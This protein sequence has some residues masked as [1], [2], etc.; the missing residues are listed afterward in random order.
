MYLKHKLVIAIIWVA[1]FLIGFLPFYLFDLRVTDSFV[2]A[3]VTFLSIVFGFYM[4][5]G[6]ILYGSSYVKELKE[7]DQKKPYQRLI[8]TFVAYFRKAS[9]FTITT[10]VFLLLNLLLPDVCKNIRLVNAFVNS[11]LLAMLSANLVF[12]VIL[13]KVFLNGLTHESTSK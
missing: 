12:L 3:A 2:E 8:H 9:Y 11:F 7:I 5:S 6:S 10:I 13:L 1:V 4:T